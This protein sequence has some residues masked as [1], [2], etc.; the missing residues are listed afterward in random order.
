MGLTDKVVPSPL[1]RLVGVS[2]Q[3]VPFWRVVLPL[4]Q[5]AAALRLNPMSSTLPSLAGK[6]A[7]MGATY[8]PPDGLKVLVLSRKSHRPPAV[9][10]VDEEDGR[11]GGHG[12]SSNCAAPPWL[13]SPKRPVFQRSG[14]AL[15]AP[16]G[17][18]EWPP[19]VDTASA[20]PWKESRN[21]YGWWS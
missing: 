9:G 17:A 1:S 16:R 19:S 5:L 12:V 3:V 6:V 13:T 21:R 10:I 18:K 15:A 8:H 14:S 11:R 20:A 2:R 4:L 7:W